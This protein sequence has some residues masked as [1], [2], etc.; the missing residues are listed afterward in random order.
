MQ[1]PANALIQ[2][3]TRTKAGDYAAFRKIMEL[4]TNSSN[5]TI[6][7]DA[8]GN[9]AYFHSNYIPRRDT[10]FDWTQPVD[11]SNPA[12]DY[13]GVLSI[14][15]TPN[16]INP[17]VGWVYNSNNWPWSAGGPDSPRRADYPRYVETGTEETPRGYH[18]LRLLARPTS[19]TIDSLIAAGFDSYLPA[20]ERMLP[21][22]V[23]AYGRL[24]AS[25]S[26]RASLA[27]EL[28][29]LRAWDF[30]WGATSVATSLAVFWGGDV[31]R[32][33]ADEARRAGVSGMAYAAERAT[34]AE[35]LAS[36]ATASGR[37]SAD[38]GSWRMP[39]GEI[40]R[41]QRLDDAITSHFDDARPS[42]P[43]PFTSSLWGSLASFGARAY[44]NTKR[45]YGTSGNSFVAAVEFGDSVRAKA[46][47]AGGES[48]D[49]GSPHFADEAGRYAAGNLR[50]VYFYRS[51]LVGHTER[52]YHPGG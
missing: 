14:D 10:A 23:A 21:P 52:G 50:D 36:L 18:A 7:A 30:R 31:L 1:N 38:F 19:W 48:G 29:E 3:Y 2:S 49:P 5:N 41:F 42:I 39:W 35:L 32:R 17:A 20:F 4:H 33:V 13:R 11:G 12:T 40:N 24:P 28:A 34:D 37:L 43:V 46:V 26:L 45:W 9:I 6:F 8:E 16:A 44:P 51:Q 22:L 15:E 27:D 47:T 25:D